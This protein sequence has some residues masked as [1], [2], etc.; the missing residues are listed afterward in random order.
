MRVTTI[1]L[2]TEQN[3]PNETISKYWMEGISPRAKQKLLIPIQQ[4]LYEIH[5]QKKKSHSL[6]AIIQI[7]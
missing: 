1:S 4:F 5:Q 7:R 3:C 2:K 6:F